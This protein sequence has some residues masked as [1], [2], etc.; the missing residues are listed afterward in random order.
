MLLFSPVA[1]VPRCCHLVVFLTTSL[2][3]G[4]LVNDLKDDAM[5]GEDPLLHDCC[6]CYC[7]RNA[8][9]PSLL[10]VTPLPSS[11]AS[12]VWKTLFLIE[13]TPLPSSE[14]SHIQIEVTLL[15]SLEASPHVWLRS[16]RCPQRRLHTAGRLCHAW[17]RRY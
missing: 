6:H 12:H 2:S 5:L 10:E 9:C 13:V 15:P 8:I 3:I 17:G 11:E 1:T 4:R 7:Q 14:A 16:L